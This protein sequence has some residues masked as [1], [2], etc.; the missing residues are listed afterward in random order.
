MSN[1]MVVRTNRDPGDGLVRTAQAI[2]SGL[3]LPVEVRSCDGEG[4]DAVVAEL[5]ARIPALVMMDPVRASGQTRLETTPCEGRIIMNSPAPVLVLRA[6]TS[7][8]VARVLVPLMGDDL[9]RGTMARAAE[10]ALRLG[11]PFGVQGGHTTEL[12]FLHVA[13]DPDEMYRELNALRDTASAYA[14]SGR[15]AHVGVHHSLRWGAS[16]PARVL[17]WVKK[18]NPGLLVLGRPHTETHA[19]LPEHSWFNVLVG[20][21]LPSLLLPRMGP[22]PEQRINLRTA[23]ALEELDVAV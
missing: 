2:G 18:L 9:S 4:G 11:G 10:W 8:R 14:E 23:L 12:H 21:A 13:A 22:E 6:G 16:R 15:F 7:L 19:G 3:D 1:I 17:A 20:A 5:R